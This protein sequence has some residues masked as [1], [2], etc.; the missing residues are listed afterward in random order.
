MW[1]MLVFQKIL[2]T[3]M[4]PWFQFDRGNEIPKY[5]FQNEET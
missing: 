5:Q 4:I 2:R 3:W 1:E